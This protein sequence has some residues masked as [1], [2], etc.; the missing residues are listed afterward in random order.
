MVR[1][2]EEG[3]YGGA[4]LRGGFALPPEVE[5]V[6]MEFRTCEFS[7]P[8]RDGS[9][10][11][12]PVITL[13]QPDEAR[14]ALTTSIGLPRK[15]FNVRRDGR[16]SL[17]FSDPTASGLEDPPTVLVQGDAE[18]PDEVLTNPGHLREYWHKIFRT[19]PAGRM[20]GANALMRYLFDWYYMR[21][22]IYVRPRRI[23]VWPNGD[24]TKSPLEVEHVG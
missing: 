1:Q 24:F 4:A 20:Y 6:F 19:Q 10:I 3:L 22:Y 21:V 14:F 17:L 16:V 7:T 15:V 13:W 23:L 9:P 18:A 8:A 2:S 5:Q 11:T 12:W